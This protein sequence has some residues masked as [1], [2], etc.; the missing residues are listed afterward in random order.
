MSAKSGL[1]KH[2]ELWRQCCNIAPGSPRWLKEGSVSTWEGGEQSRENDNAIPWCAAQR[3]QHHGQCHSKGHWLAGM[4][5]CPRVCCSDQGGECIQCQAKDATGQP[6]AST[7]S[8][9]LY[10]P[11]PPLREH[12]GIC[13]PPCSSG[14]PSAF[15]TMTKQRTNKIGRGWAMEIEH[16]T[17]LDTKSYLGGPYFMNSLNDKKNDKKD[18]WDRHLDLTLLKLDPIGGY[19]YFT[20][21]SVHYHHWSGFAYLMDVAATVVSNR[22]PSKKMFPN[23]FLHCCSFMGSC[24]FQ[25]N[26]NILLLYTSCIHLL[27]GGAHL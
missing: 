23:L 4:V 19:F 15:Q 12:S 1:P 18:K 27:F 8:Q 11:I 25:V 3:Q 17:W 7:S 22:C 6:C 9:L 16:N 10:P 2:K 5:W 13:P 21:E 14:W 24:I 26:R 20:N